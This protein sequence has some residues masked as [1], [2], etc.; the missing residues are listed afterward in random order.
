MKD[1]IIDYL[2]TQLTAHKL[3]AVDADTRHEEHIHLD[4][5][6]SL[7]QMVNYLRTAMIAT[8]NYTSISNLSEQIQQQSEDRCYRVEPQ[9]M[10]GTK[11]DQ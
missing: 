5:V 9:L 4:K 6:E 8:F 10:Y 1:Q 11:E 3:S 7:Q 2:L